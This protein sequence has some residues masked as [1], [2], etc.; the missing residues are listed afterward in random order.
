[1]RGMSRRR[2]QD[3][4]PHPTHHCEHPGCNMPAEFQ[5]PQSPDRLDVRIWLCQKHLRDHNRNWDFFRGWSQ[6]QI[7]DF[8]QDALT[9]HRPTWNTVERVGLTPE[10]LYAALENFMRDNGVPHPRRAAPVMPAKD[11][12]A[13]AVLEVDTPPLTISALK[14]HYKLLAKRYHP[15]AN[16]G[17]KKAEETF[18]TIT[19][20]YAHLVAGME[21]QPTN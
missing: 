11:R 17:D 20:A 1:M 9:G 4:S 7:E 10:R 19:A 12:K 14:R 18:K 13:W 5:A 15:D 6:E 16:P 21:K 8:M 3:E 2:N